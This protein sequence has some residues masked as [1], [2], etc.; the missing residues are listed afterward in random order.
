M[1]EIGCVDSPTPEVLMIVLSGVYTFNL[2]KNWEFYLGQIFFLYEAKYL[3][4]IFYQS[5]CFIEGQFLVQITL[6]IL[7]AAAYQLGNTNSRMITE[8]NQ[9]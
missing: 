5:F 3:G 2:S 9:Q 4:Q 8:V 7:G 6:Q 1:K